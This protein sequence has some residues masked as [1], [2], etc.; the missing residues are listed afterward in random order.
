MGDCMIL[1]VESVLGL[2]RGSEIPPSPSA[3]DQRDH[4]HENEDEQQDL[5]DPDERT[6]EHHEAE[7][8]GKQ[9]EYREDN[10]VVQ[11]ENYSFL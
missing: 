1:L 7:D 3:Q 10:S 6:A 5:G 4:Q 9:G 11:N 8:A 2:I